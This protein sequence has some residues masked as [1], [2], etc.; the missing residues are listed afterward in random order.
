MGGLDRVLLGLALVGLITIGE[1]IRN[2][3]REILEE[4]KK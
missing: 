2:V 1:Q 3:L 4:I